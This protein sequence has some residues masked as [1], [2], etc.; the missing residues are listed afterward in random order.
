MMKLNYCIFFMV[1]LKSC[2]SKDACSYT[3]RSASRG[4]IISGSMWTTTTTDRVSCLWECSRR[5]GCKSFQYSSFSSYCR[6]YSTYINDDLQATDEP[7]SSV[8]E[9]YN[10]WPDL[11]LSTHGGPR[12]F[13][14]SCNHDGDCDVRE[15]TCYGGSCSCMTGLSYDASNMACVVYCQRYGSSFSEY[16]VTSAITT[17]NHTWGPTVDAPGECRDVCL[18]EEHFECIVAW[19]VQ[20]SDGEYSCEYGSTWNTPGSSVYEMFHSS[21][22]LY[23]RHC[24]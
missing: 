4:G 6:G 5:S 13:G 24:A 17:A 19:A 18:Q 11:V 23:V 15:S 8:V 12:I 14:S 7:E 2:Q 22:I 3:L 9:Y 1:I 16:S 21:S 10:M 20:I